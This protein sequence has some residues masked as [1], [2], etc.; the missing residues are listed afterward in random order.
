MPNANTIASAYVQI[1]PS[2]TGLTSSLSSAMGDAGAKAGEAGGNTAGSFFNKAL[3]TFMTVYVAKTIK[4]VF[5]KAFQEGAAL[6]QSLGGVETIYSYA[7]AFLIV[8][9]N[10]KQAFETAG[11]S[12]NTYM[13]QATQFGAALVQSLGG[14]AVTAAQT[15]DVAIR[16]MAD[17]AN[18]FGTDIASIQAAY[19]G[20]AKQNYT[21]LDNLRLGYGGTKTEMERLLARA[22]ELTG[23]HYDITNL[24]DVYNAIHAIQDDLG[25]TGTTADEASKTFSGSMASMSAAAQ[26]LLGHL[27]LGEDITQDLNN[28]TTTFSTFFQ[29]NLVPMLTNI[30]KAL[31]GAVVSILRNL[32]PTLIPTAVGVLMEAVPS[33][34]SGLV[35]L[36]QVLAS[37]LP[38]ML[39]DFF[40][41]LPGIIHM[42][43]DSLIEDKN[44]A[45]LIQGVTDLVLGIVDALP[46]IINSII[47]CL[48]DLI[49]L[50]VS[51]TLESF[52][53]ILGA[54][55]QIIAKLAVKLPEIIKGLWSAL[56]RSVVLIVE[57]LIEHAKEFPKAA[58]EWISKLWE[59][60]KENLGELPQKAV[61]KIGDIVSA[62]TQ[63]V[64]DFIQI[65]KNLVMGLWNGIKSGWTWLTTKVKELAN[66]LL[67]GV[68]K[69]LGIAS[70]SKEF[71]EV[72][73]F[74]TE[75][76][77]IGIGSSDAVAHV[78]DEVGDVLDEVNGA[79]MAGVTAAVSVGGM[80][81]DSIYTALASSVA[82]INGK[83]NHLQIVMD[84]GALVGAI[85][86][87]M[88]GKLG[89]L[90]NLTARGATV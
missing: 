36:V 86:E 71:A 89:K 69:V 30:L 45:L 62:I 76:L 74:I 77:A 50:I 1:L 52:P 7:D 34:I 38:K 33:L 39:T 6:Q 17:N 5:Q 15:A 78:R 51:A 88:D 40:A 84:S 22:E 79:T 12:A 56:A 61:Q 65:G 16:D 18:K 23:V 58:K 73:R 31:P 53:L 48:P 24:N 9:K 27:A 66:S 68:K 11:V 81:G 60:M 14:D 83:L 20:F 55:I 85:G 75:G 3:K 57:K 10:A 43:I 2:T 21:M 4:D 59:Q 41:A 87:K 70:P 63:K 29:N 80:E 32:L 42:L 37:N 54:A 44:L 49:E 64:S 46:D 19:Q 67:S 72:G 8:E 47:E 26:N 90:S 35:Q 13:E 28:L 82:E 25:V